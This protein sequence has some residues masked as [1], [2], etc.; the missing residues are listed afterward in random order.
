MSTLI[1]AHALMACKGKAPE[2]HVQLGAAETAKTE[3]LK[4]KTTKAPTTPS[5]TPTSPP[6]SPPDPNVRPAGWATGPMSTL[7]PFA[8]KLARSAQAALIEGKT[9][10]EA[11]APFEA[12]IQLKLR[13]E[14]AA[15]KAR[16]VEIM[17]MELELVF[18]QGS[19]VHYYLRTFVYPAK[20]GPEFFK[21]D[22][23][24]PSEGKLAVPY[25]PL[26]ATAKIAPELTQAAE[27]LAGLLRDGRCKLLPII[28]P[29][30]LKGKVKPGPMQLSMHS[31]L[32]KAALLRQ[33]TCSKLPSFDKTDLQ[34]RVDDFALVVFGAKEEVLG[35]LHGELSLHK[36]ELKVELSRF[37]LFP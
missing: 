35:T 34:M 21:I 3:A 14:L 7:L 15:A 36:G 22:G 1:L 16:T 23:R 29:Q 25:W 10:A 27:G 17:G 33:K 6:A 37:R 8:Q 19:K 32:R 18:T 31:N 12:N 30:T 4:A 28:S 9:P 24:T 5:P 11:F 26:S 20:G 13:D 2:R